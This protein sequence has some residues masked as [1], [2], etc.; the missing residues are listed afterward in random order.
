MAKEHKVVLAVGEHLHVSLVRDGRVMTA[1]SIQT[2]DGFMLTLCGGPSVAGDIGGD[3]TGSA[4][5]LGSGEAGPWNDGG[6]S[7][8][9]PKE[10]SPPE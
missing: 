6:F 4:K 3:G 7:I 5:P 9:E 8:A 10:P 2:L 1:Y